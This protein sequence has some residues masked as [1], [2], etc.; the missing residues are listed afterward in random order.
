MSAHTWAYTCEYAHM[1]TFTR[2]SSHGCVLVTAYTWV[3]TCAWALVSMHTVPCFMSS[4]ASF[5][6]VGVLVALHA[7]STVVKAGVQI[8]LLRYRSRNWGWSFYVPAEVKC[9][10]ST[11]IVIACLD[12]ACKL[13]YSLHCF[14]GS[15]ALAFSSF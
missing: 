8:R 15:D 13:E 1:G 9:H 14:V 11:V 4:I 10:N 3:R 12:C 6:H 5:R 2:L 7:S